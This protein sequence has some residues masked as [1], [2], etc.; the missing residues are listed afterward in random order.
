MGHAHARPG[1]HRARLLAVLLLTA[2]VSLAQVVGGLLTGSLALVA[3]A[4]HGLTDATGLGLALMAATLATR[5]ATSRRSYG[6]LRA[7]ALAALVNGLLVSGLAAWVLWEAVR[8]WND[9]VEIDGGPMIAVACLGVAANAA[10][11]VILRPA[12]HTSLNLRGAH[13]EVLGDLLGSLAVVVAGVVVVTTGWTRAD[14]AASVAIGVLILP[15]ALVLLRDVADVLLEAVPPGVDLEEV[16]G[17]LLQVAGVVD[18][19]DLHAWTIG[20]GVPALTA[21][22]TV[23]DEDPP[24]DGQLLDR[25]QECVRTGFGIDHATFQIEPEGHRGHEPEGHA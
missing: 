21:H 4:A 11:L 15:R 2:A 12:A 7:E 22:V 6:W 19:H 3:D 13:L 18:V 9:P 1:A 25:L 8:R 5:P 17:R 10:G 20:T 16:R 23:A 24:Y 14:V